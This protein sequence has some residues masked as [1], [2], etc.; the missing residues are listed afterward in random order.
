[1]LGVK[2]FRSVLS[3]SKK[4]SDSV[5]ELLSVPFLKCGIIF[6]ALAAETWGIMRGFILQNQRAQGNRINQERAYLVQFIQN[7]SAGFFIREVKLSREMLLKNFMITGGADP[8]V[9]FRFSQRLLLTSKSINHFLPC[10]RSFVWPHWSHVPGLMNSPLESFIDSHWQTREIPGKESHPDSSGLEWNSS[11]L[12]IYHS[13]QMEKHTLPRSILFQKFVKPPWKA[14]GS[15]RI[16]QFG[17][18]RAIQWTIFG[19]LLACEEMFT[20]RCRIMA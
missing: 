3:W 6:A 2:L 12:L 15:Q 18:L 8:F 4:C 13:E 19:W 14:E 16:G 10:F 17:K 7:S 1:M 20:C 9:Y 5:V 11:A